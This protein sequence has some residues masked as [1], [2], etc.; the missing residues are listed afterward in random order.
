VTSRPP[1]LVV[2][3]EPS[4]DRIAASVAR[5]ARGHGVATLGMGGAA[6]AAE[7]MELVADLRRSAAMGISEVSRRFPAVLRAYRTLRHSAKSLRPSAAVLIDYVEFNLRLGRFLRALGVRVLWC[8]APQVW[9]WRPGRRATFGR[10]LDRMATI[11]PFEPPLWREKGIEAR[12]VGHPALDAP[13]VERAAARRSLQ[14]ADDVS[15]VAILPG[16]R[17]HE[18]RRHLPIM[19]AALRE[20]SR[21]GHGATARVL[22]APW[23]DAETRRWLERESRGVPVVDVSPVMGA[24]A[25][26][27]AFD[28]ALVAS[29]TASL[30]CALVGALPVVVYRVSRLTAAIARPLLRTPHIALPNVLLGDRVF[31]ELL[32]QRA[33]PVAMA[34]AVH[35]M[36]ERRGESRALGERL[37]ALLHCADDPSARTGERIFAMLHDWLPGSGS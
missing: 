1:L 14:L 13:Q 3:G 12:Y 29:G 27:P 35:Q 10:A 9:A 20:L 32:Q 11:L 6:S 25:H 5:A 37:R 28:A 19:L 36:L 7:G 17:P 18:V 21:H 34:R 16:S 15:A 24:A 33:E 31:P 30:E 23:L 26:L 4:A 8:V 2:A 22:A